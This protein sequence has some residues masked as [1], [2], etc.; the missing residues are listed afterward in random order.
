M[1]SSEGKEC[2]LAI[3]CAGDIFAELCLRG[4]GERLETATAM[5][6]TV[7]AMRQIRKKVEKDYGVLL[8]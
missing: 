2:P 3:N 6:A 5:K 4:F 8:Q 7:L 1:L